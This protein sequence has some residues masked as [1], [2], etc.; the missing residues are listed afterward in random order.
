MS[1]LRTFRV[2]LDVSV[3]DRFDDIE[4]EEELMRAAEDAARRLMAD[5]ADVEI[6]ELTEYTEEV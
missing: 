5:G 1:L 4:H 2:S 6:V 3:V